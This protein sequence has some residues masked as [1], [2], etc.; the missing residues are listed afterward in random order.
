MLIRP[1]AKLNRDLNKT[2]LVVQKKL[3]KVTLVNMFRV[4]VSLSSGEICGCRVT[5]FRLKE[6][7]DR[8][9]NRLSEEN[10]ESGNN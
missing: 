5:R 4:S 1:L 6:R 3:F 7:T 8:S 2:T 9:C 10:E